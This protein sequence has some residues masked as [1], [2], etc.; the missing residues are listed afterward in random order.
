MSKCV[1]ETFLV[2]SLSIYLSVVPGCESASSHSIPA[3]CFSRRRK[4]EEVPHLDMP[5]HT[6][7]KI[8]PSSYGVQDEK[9]PLM[10][11]NESPPIDEAKTPPPQSEAAQHEF[12]R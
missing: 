10:E 1:R 6:V 4:V 9:F 5:L 8:A 3:L 12:S 2:I 7:V 11:E